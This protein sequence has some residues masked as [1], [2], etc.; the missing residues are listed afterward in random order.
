M[1]TEVEPAEPEAAF[2]V[3]STR[4]TAGGLEITGYARPG[5]RGTTWLSSMFTSLTLRPAEGAD[6]TVT[7]RTRH[8]NLPEVTDDS[9]Q[10]RYNHDWAGFTA[11]VDPARLRHQGRWQEGDWLIEATVRSGLRQEHGPLTQYWCGSGEYPLV[12]WVDRDVRVLP[13]F[14]DDALRLRIE[15]VRHR[16]TAVTPFDGGLELALHAA[17]CPEG[18]VL[19]L[20]HRQS[21]TELTFPLVPADGPAAHTVRVPFAPFVVDGDPSH[22]MEHWGPELLRPDGGTVRPVMDDR[23]GP[24]SAQHPLPGSDRLLYVKQLADGYPQF[25]VQ[26][27]TGL[28]ERITPAGDGFDL[29]GEAPLGGD[30]PLELVL[31]HSNGTGEVHHP[32]ERGERFSC[33]LPALSAC[34]DGSLR[35]LPKGVWEL[36]IRPVGRADAEQPL[37]VAPQAL[38]ALPVRVTVGSAAT[39]S[40]SVLLQRRWHDTLILDSTP[41]LAAAERSAFTQHRLL[42]ETYPAARRRPLRETVLYDVFGGRGYSDSPRAIH[43]EL[44]RRRT[45]LEHLWVIDDAQG[46]VPEG[47]RAIR[48]H[49]PEWYEALG[50]SRYLVGNTHFPDFIERRPGQVIVQTWH[51]SLLKRIAHDVENA[52]LSDAGYLTA[53]DREAPQWSLLVSPSSFA[54]PI[55]RRAFRYEGEI[56]ESGY[57]RGDVL[58]RGTGAQTVRERLGIPAGKRIVL[59]APTWREDQQRESGDGFHLGLRLDLDAARTELGA[60]HVLLVRPHSHVRE[61]LPGAGDGFLYDVGDYPDVQEL[62]LAADV[63]VTDYSSIMF[64]FAITGRPILF[65]TYDLEHYR[66][67]LRGFYFD[68]ESEAPGP[69]IPTSPELLTALRDLAGS[70]ALPARY[71][72]AYQRFRATHCHLDDG[73]AAARV[74]DRMLAIG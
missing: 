37:I 54:T 19:R 15:V 39:G 71:A 62:L 17:D 48:S 5:G 53:L 44:V 13:S 63:L 32:V 22:E 24:L 57:P 9:G 25:C 26:S 3:R 59:Y 46:E 61:P 31:R 1:D 58:A 64:D 50:T 73:G 51:G 10:H 68:L 72:D 33:H 11:T 40:K 43:A 65:F 67:T 38:A 21:S 42:T 60:D 14:A 27:G 56:L 41:V 69:L 35:P 23:G 20:R 74:V 29:T 49:S 70:D 36:R 30:G 8:L 16:I 12:H 55:L 47:V 28:I 52:W 4:W 45:P 34:S 66:D 7:V 2:G 6:R 18:T